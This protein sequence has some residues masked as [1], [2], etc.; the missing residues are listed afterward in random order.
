MRHRFISYERQ[1]RK[2]VQISTTEVSD[3]ECH[4]I[5]TT[6][7][8][9]CD[10]GT[11]WRQNDPWKEGQKWRKMDITEVENGPHSAD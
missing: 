1:K 6:I 10:D 4:F 11:L 8:A 7:Y 9:L 3:A 2:I 5:T